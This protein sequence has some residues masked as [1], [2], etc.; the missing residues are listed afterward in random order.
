MIE[1]DIKDGIAIIPNGTTMIE[2]GDFCDCTSL[3]SIIIPESVTKI[4]GEAFSNNTSLKT[5]IVPNACI[6]YYKDAL[7]EELKEL[8]VGI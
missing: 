1:F 4:E 6:D 8:V 7:P 5:I 2:D 3:V